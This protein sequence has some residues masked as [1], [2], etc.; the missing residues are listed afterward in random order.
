MTYND[1]FPSILRTVTDLLQNPFFR[2]GQRRLILFFQ[3]SGMG[4]TRASGKAEW[5]T[6]L[7]GCLF[8]AGVYFVYICVYIC[9]C[10]CWVYMCIFYV[11]ICS[12]ACGFV[13]IYVNIKNN[14]YVLVHTHSTVL[15]VSDCKQ[16]CIYIKLYEQ[17]SN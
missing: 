2:Q 15:C 16:L 5:L 12:S 9:I 11:Y 10:V 14:V 7:G 17:I 3:E 13:C 6:Q 8:W 1:M 4:E